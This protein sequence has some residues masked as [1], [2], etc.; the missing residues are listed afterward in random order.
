MLELKGDKYQVV[1]NPDTANIVFEGSLLLNG[2]PAY[3]PILQLLK[4]AAE[5]QEPNPLVVD[6]C[7]L[8]FMNSSGINMLTKFVMYVSDVKKLKLILT[9]Q[10]QKKIAWQEKLCINLQRLLPS[11]QTQLLD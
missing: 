4:Q 11:L 10:A 1:Y 9:F 6:I 5:E 7:S 2:A 8:K 3:E